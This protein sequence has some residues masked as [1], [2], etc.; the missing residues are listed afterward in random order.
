LLRWTCK[1]LKNLKI[2]LSPTHSHAPSR[3]AAGQAASPTFLLLVEPRRLLSP[4]PAPHRRALARA[5]EGGPRSATPMRWIQPSAAR[6]IWPSA[7]RLALAPGGAGA[8]G[9]W[10]VDGARPAARVPGQ[11]GGRRGRHRGGRW[12]KPAVEPGRRRSWAGGGGWGEGGE[13]FSFLF[14]QIF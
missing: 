4:P 11:S 12:T 2:P 5:G 6:W 13:F 9:V 10:A 14:F 1:N 7:A 3:T 8:G